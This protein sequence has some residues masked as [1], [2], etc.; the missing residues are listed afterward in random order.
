M[1]ETAFVAG[2]VNKDNQL[3]LGEFR[4][5]LRHVKGNELSDAEITAM[6]DECRHGDSE[7]ILVD[8]AS[9]RVASCD[10]PPTAPAVRLRSSGHEAPP[11]NRALPEEP[12]RA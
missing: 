6:Y 2:D 3:S 8:G 9:S 5:L 12:C 10:L 1:L 4:V 11:A 7:T